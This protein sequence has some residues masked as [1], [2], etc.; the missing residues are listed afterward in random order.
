MTS[1]SPLIADV[2]RR[3]M[4][5]TQRFWSGWL[6]VMAIFSRVVALRSGAQRV[7]ALGKAMLFYRDVV[8]GL[9]YFLISFGIT[10]SA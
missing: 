2:A 3:S 1:R 5:V 10:Q 9:N 6:S 4:T 7:T 8:P